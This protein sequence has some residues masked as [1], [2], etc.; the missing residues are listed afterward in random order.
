MLL[1]NTA[2][3]IL[4]NKYTYT[5]SSHA[6]INT[7]WAMLPVPTE[8]EWGPPEPD[9]S[10]SSAPQA[11]WSLWHES[12]QT[13]SCVVRRQRATIRA[14]Q[15]KRSTVVGR[16]AWTQFFGFSEHHVLT[17]NMGAPGSWTDHVVR[18]RT[19]VLWGQTGLDLNSN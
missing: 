16:V 11:H 5:H 4:I 19:S 6:R 3:N 2:S 14:V 15:G 1:Q 12:G 8:P 18:L 9:R 7:I 17:Y 13:G 10:G